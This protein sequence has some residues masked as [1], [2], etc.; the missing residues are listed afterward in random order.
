MDEPAESGAD[1]YAI[2]EEYCQ[3]IDDNKQPRLTIDRSSFL[4]KAITEKIDNFTNYSSQLIVDVFSG[5]KQA[6]G[7][8]RLWNQNFSE[9]T[10]YI[11]SIIPY[12]GYTNYDL[13][14]ELISFFINKVSAHKDILREYLEKERTEKSINNAKRPISARLSELEHYA[15]EY[16]GFGLATF[17]LELFPE[18][19]DLA[20][21]H[22][23]SS[24]STPPIPSEAPIK[25][26]DREPG[27]TPP[28]FVRRAYAPWLE[29]GLSK[30]VLRSLD[31]TLVTE[32]N[33]W[34]RDG[35][36]MPADV[37]ILTVSEE[38]RQLLD[39]GPEAIH[40]HLGKFTGAEAV[41]EARR[42]TMAKHRS[43]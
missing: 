9:V 4:A 7:A 3:A 11:R 1:A 33:K 25:W 22:S 17:A 23:H 34:V 19:K 18:L 12:D 37:K 43:K 30:R 40:E 36:A 14:E 13:Q 21:K 5:D 10:D 35:N 32:L 31:P 38:N 42:L 41:R 39:A 26:K 20:Q 2:I 24:S 15:N 8:L 29:G 27:E 16:R 6:S 28:D